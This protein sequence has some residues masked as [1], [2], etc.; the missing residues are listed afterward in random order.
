M[1]FFRLRRSAEFGVQR[2]NKFNPCGASQRL[3]F[4]PILKILAHNF[5]E[6]PTA[7]PAPR[8][9]RHIGARLTPNENS[10]AG[11]PFEFSMFGTESEGTH[12]LP[13]AL[14]VGPL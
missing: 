9:F 10:A 4:C 8:G 14:S 1:A 11:S 5:I 12:C 2:G 3:N 13:P 7:K 6:V